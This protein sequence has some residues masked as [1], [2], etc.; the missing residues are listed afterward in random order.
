MAEVLLKNQND[1]L[2]KPYLRNPLIH[3]RIIVK[4]MN[5]SPKPVKQKRK[6]DSKVWGSPDWYGSVD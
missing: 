4:G 3:F 6:R 5:L 1:L 2:H